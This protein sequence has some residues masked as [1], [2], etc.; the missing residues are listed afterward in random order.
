ML[1]FNLQVFFFTC[2][3]LF[4]HKNKL[5]S[6]MKDRFPIENS[7]IFLWRK[8]LVL[9]LTLF[10]IFSSFYTFLMFSSKNKIYCVEFEDTL[11]CLDS[12]ESNTIVLIFFLCLLISQCV[13]H[14]HIIEIGNLRILFIVFFYLLW[15]YSLILLWLYS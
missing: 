1:A 10:L 12:W 11:E 8:V 14:K 2:V 6:R 7:L 5:T 4:R 15:L 3:L 13:N 9:Q